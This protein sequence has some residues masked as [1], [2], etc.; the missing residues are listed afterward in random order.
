MQDIFQACRGWTIATFQHVTEDDFLIQLLGGSVGDLTVYSEAARRRKLS[1]SS[2]MSWSTSPPSRRELLFTF[3]YYNPTADPSADVFVA[4]AVAAAFES[5]LPATL[6][7]V[8]EGYVPTKYDQ[9][10]LAAA[11]ADIQRLF[12]HNEVGDILRGAVLSPVSNIDTNFAAAVSN[13]SPLFKLPVDA[14]QRGRD[15]GLPTYNDVRQVSVFTRF[16]TRGKRRCMDGGSAGES[17][18]FGCG[19]MAFQALFQHPETNLDVR[20]S[21]RLNRSS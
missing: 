13:A 17:L 5:A 9:I 2:S 21:A 20:E 16:S 14:I 11:S 8:S 1:L 19:N 6:R 4:G 3:E 12:E 18:P 7:I 15:H 10:E